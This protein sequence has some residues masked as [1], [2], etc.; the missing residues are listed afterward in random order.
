MPW[1]INITDQWAEKCRF[2][3]RAAMFVNAMLLALASIY[4]VGQV[5]WHVI[6]FLNRTIFSHPW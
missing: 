1:K 3:L 5:I 4:I 6:G 2:A